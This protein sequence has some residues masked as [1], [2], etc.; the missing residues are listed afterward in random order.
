MMLLALAANTS[1][2]G[3]PVLASLLARDNHLPHVFGLR[4]DRQVYRYGV[5][6][7]AAIASVLLVAAEGDTQKLVPV[8]AIGVLR[9]LHPL[10]GR[11]GP[12]LA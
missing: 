4:A 7:L 10:P 11:H 1:F 12:A 5:V 9:R 6:A 2:G 3:M 8:F